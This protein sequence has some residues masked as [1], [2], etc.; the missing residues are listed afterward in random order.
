M[1][2]SWQHIRNNHEPTKQ[3]AETLEQSM[4]SN[5]ADVAKDAATDSGV[6]WWNA[7]RI[8]RRSRDLVQ[9]LISQA[10]FSARFA[11]RSA[12]VMGRQEAERD[13]YRRHLTVVPTRSD[14]SVAARAEREVTEKIAATAPVSIRSGDALYNQTLSAII[15]Q[16]AQSQAHRLRVAQ[17]VLDRLTAAG[18]TG[19][20]DKRNRRL[21]LVSYIEMVTKTVAA[22]AMLDSHVQTLSAHGQS[23]AVIDGAVDCCEICAP[24]HGSLVVIDGATPPESVQVMGTLAD[25]R[26]AGVW[27]PHCRCEIRNWDVGDPLPEPPKIDPQLYKDRQHLRSLEREVRAAKR[28]HAGAMTPQAQLAAGKRI[29]AAQAKIRAHVGATDV[30]RQRRREQIGRAL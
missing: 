24:W 25:A 14:V 5:V 2:I 1:A 28:V 26:D 19:F 16:P 30:R 8:R 29:R 27:H 23:L 18:I 21:N 9:R 15:G 6:S 3:T 20:I 7:L 4:I 11:V 13:L 10:V 17:A 12:A 22:D